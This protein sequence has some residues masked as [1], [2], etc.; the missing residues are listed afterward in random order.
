MLF[1][2]SIPSLSKEKPSGKPGY[3][4]KVPWG[5]WN[6]SKGREFMTVVFDGNR[7]RSAIPLMCRMRDDLPPKMDKLRSWVKQPILLVWGPPKADL[8][9]RI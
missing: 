7:L 2:V 5:A 8:K 3:N 4:Q 9:T 6:Q 1:P